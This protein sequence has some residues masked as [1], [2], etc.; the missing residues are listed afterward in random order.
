MELS[1]EMK[2]DL[3]LK[4]IHSGEIN[5]ALTG[6]IYKDK[7]WV[8]NYLCNPIAAVDLMDTM[9][10]NFKKVALQYQDEIVLFSLD[11]KTV[12]YKE[13]LDRVD[14]I[15][16]G[17][18]AIGLQEGDVI[19][20]LSTNSV[21]EPIPLLAA[22]KL[23]AMVKYIDYSKDIKDVIKSV[24][25]TTLRMII[26]DEVLAPLIQT[27]NSNNIP[28]VISD[29]KEYK[30]DHNTYN[31][32]M[33]EKLGEED[34]FVKTESVS[35]DA[36]RPALMITSSGTTGKPKP[37]VHT[38]YSVNSAVQKILYTDYKIGNGSVMLKVIPAHIGLG[39]I[40]TLYTSLIS[41]TKLIFVRGGSPVESVQN[42]VKF[43]CE[44]PQFCEKNNISRD[45]PLNIFA[46]PMFY[47][48]IASQMEIIPDLSYIGSMLAAGS[49]T[50]SEEVVNLFKL[51]NTKGCNSYIC[52]GYG[53]NEM[54]GAV[55]LNSDN[56]NKAGS[57]GYPVI[58][59]DIRVV[60]RDTLE[61]LPPCK[62]GLILERAESLFAYYEGMPSETKD[63]KITLS[64]GSEWFNT[65]DIGYIDCDGYIYITGRT[66]R[67]MIRFNCKIALESIE[68]KIKMHPDVK[69]CALVAVQHNDDENDFPF[70]YIHSESMD[71]EGK[72]FSDL[73]KKG[74]T[75]SDYE[76]PEIIHFVEKLPYMNNGKIDYQFLEKLARE[77]LKDKKIYA[78][79]AF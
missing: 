25:E 9:Y 63:A 34:E 5:E 19:G 46:A 15:S 39:I 74:V 49:K 72:L 29:Y 42:T 32:E 57:A 4:K 71:L 62:E 54:G 30:L 76:V 43:I 40:T 55:T 45:K 24:N 16:A 35:F 77:E 56:N 36:N 8:K 59:T 67:A 27:I 69:D 26:F 41:H 20:V 66:S 38:D 68:E 52:N 18:K 3:H 13:L 61:I 64:D 33:L 44:Y 53:Q 58:G 51:Y 11:G 65:K 10:N 31:Y 23:G 79:R 37:I 17:L 22:N 48:A 78:K 60:D 2:R 6:D 1:N 7:P 73:E 28:V 47:K 21:E 14:K 12:T 75:F 70:C 50:L